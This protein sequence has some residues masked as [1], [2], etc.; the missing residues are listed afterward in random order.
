MRISDWSS[1]VCS[2]DLLIDTA[3]ADGHGTRTAIINDCG[4]WTYAELGDLAARIAGLIETEGLVPGSRGLLRGPNT[5]TLIACWLGSIRAGCV[6]VTTVPLL[7][8]LELPPIVTRAAP[9]LAWIYARTVNAMGGV[10]WLEASG[11]RTLTLERDIGR[12][13]LARRPT[14]TPPP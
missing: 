11:C 2:S 7:G 13:E 6:A 4:S 9:M 5:A 1:D 8:A 10:Q 3:I 14:R 12:G